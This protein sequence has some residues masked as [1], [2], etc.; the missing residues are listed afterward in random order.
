[1]R[2]Y[3]FTYKVTN[4]LGV[5]SEFE[6][7]LACTAKNLSEAIEEL[8]KESHSCTMPVIVYTYSEPI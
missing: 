4:A 1:M 6:N 2:Q 5:A 7:T 8:V 3:I